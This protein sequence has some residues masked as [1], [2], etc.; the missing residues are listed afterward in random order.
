MSTVLII[1]LSIFTILSLLKIFTQYFY[2]R[3]WLKYRIRKGQH[4]SQV[5]RRFF[6]D[7]F[8]VNLEED[9]SL[10]F[11]VIFRDSCLY[12]KKKVGDHIN[13]LYG[14]AC[15]KHHE[16]SIRVGWRCDSVTHGRISLWAY[17]YHDR[18]L[19]YEL[20]GHT[21]VETLEKITIQVSEKELTVLL[22]DMDNNDVA[23]AQHTEYLDNKMDC[24]KIGRYKLFPYFGGQPVAPHDMQIDIYEIE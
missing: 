7:R 16:N 6:W 21:Y 20:L 2:Q 3:K 9:K 17:W 10:T 14:I 23:I 12:D 15:G 4:F 24:N 1:A 22:L 18:D 8:K 13:K 11:L 19:G 5:K